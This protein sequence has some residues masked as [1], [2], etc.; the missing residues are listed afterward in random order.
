MALYELD[1][2]APQLAD[3]AWVADSAQVIG[4]VVRGGGEK[5]VFVYNANKNRIAENWFEGCP[6]GIHFTAGSEGNSM[7]GNAFVANQM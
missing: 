1:G 6:I 2:V 7:T 4:N 5:C 3:T